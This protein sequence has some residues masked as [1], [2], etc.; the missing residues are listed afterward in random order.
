M[1][2]IRVTVTPDKA[3]KV[4]QDRI[5]LG[6][7]IRSLVDLPH[8]VASDWC[9]TNVEVLKSVFEGP[10]V[11]RQYRTVCETHH[12]EW[13]FQDPPKTDYPRDEVARQVHEQV[14]FLEHL[15]PDIDEVAKKKV[16]IVHGRD[17]GTRETVAR[18]LEKLGL[19]VTILDEQA[20]ASKTIIEKFEEYSA[21][22]YAVVLL[23]PDDV[24][25]LR[26]DSVLSPR[27][28][29]NVILEMGFF[30]GRLGRDRVS[31]LLKGDVEEPSDIH[32]I[33]Y[34]R[35]DEGDGWVLK[36]ARNLHHAGIPIDPKIVVGLRD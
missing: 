9:V 1:A 30:L 16:F 32:G 36:L 25:G 8:R 23:T 24:G 21:V 12:C 28:R 10:E 4:L 31:V 11:P 6:R 5:D 35:M 7:I 33:V 3:K 20:D 17:M 26:H 19:E 34:N 15:L 13:M 2:Q 27:A 18:F 29:Q 22:A 14:W